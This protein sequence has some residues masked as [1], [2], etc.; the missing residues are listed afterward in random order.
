[1]RFTSLSKFFFASVLCLLL[2]TY[3]Q[4]QTG[5]T[6][7]LPVAEYYEGGQEK[8]LADIQKMTVYPPMAKRNRIQ[9][10]CVVAITLEE[11]GK[12]TNQKLIKGIGGGTGD[13]AMRVVSQ[14]KFK[15]PGYRFDTFVPVKFALSQ[16]SK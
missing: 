5:A 12:I 8:M 4:A 3:V 9:G 16:A 10:E 15:A 1:M 14:L 13:E 2:G 6:K 7:S 11:N